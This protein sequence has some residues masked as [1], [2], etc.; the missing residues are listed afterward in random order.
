MQTIQQVNLITLGTPGELWMT[1][2][3]VTK[4]GLVGI[5]ATQEGCDMTFAYLGQVALTGVS[6]PLDSSGLPDE[7]EILEAATEY[8]LKCVSKVI[9]QIPVTLEGE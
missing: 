4:Y 5:H 3:V 2:W 7:D 8:A 6:V 9:E 1:G